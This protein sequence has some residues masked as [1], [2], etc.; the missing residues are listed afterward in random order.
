MLPTKNF[1][2]C[3]GLNKE[4]LLAK[5]LGL[6]KT[7]TAVVLPYSSPREE[8]MQ[9]VIS[10]AQSAKIPVIRPKQADLERA[11]RSTGAD[12]LVSAGYPYLLKP[13]ALSVCRYNINIHPSLL[14]K[15]RG[16]AATWYVLAN[17][18]TEGGVTVHLI[19]EGMDTGNILM[20]GNFPLGPFDT[21]KSYM[22]KAAELEPALLEGAI[23]KL[24][25]GDVRGVP[26][27]ES[28][29]SSYIGRRSWEDSEF[30]PNRSILELYDFIKACDPDR[31][32]A[33]FKVAGQCVGVKLFRP[34]RPEDEDDLI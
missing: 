15:Y 8:R 20:Q 6:G 25:S 4:S 22:R 27:D 9:G 7:V 21:I 11:L 14:P 5:L 13:E 31:F 32:P 17:G 2:F 18:E 28:K 34:N 19:D 30:D 10:A 23:S 26:Q 29:S 24:D 1:V 12:T 16:P 3:T 33:F